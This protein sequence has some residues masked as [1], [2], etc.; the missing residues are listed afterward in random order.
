LNNYP[1]S[2]FAK[3]YTITGNQIIDEISSLIL[4]EAGSGSQKLPFWFC[5]HGDASI[6]SSN[7]FSSSGEI[8]FNFRHIQWASMGG[9]LFFAGFIQKM[10]EHPFSCPLPLRLTPTD[11]G[12]SFARVT[13]ALVAI[14]RAV[15]NFPHIIGN[16]CWQRCPVGQGK[17]GVLCIKEPKVVQTRSLKSSSFTHFEW[18]LIPLSMHHRQSCAFFGVSKVRKTCETMDESFF[19]HIINNQILF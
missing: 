9:T 12:S 16:N 4:G 11:G 17:E 3:T 19:G 2:M 5:L 10:H 6:Q 8:K 7:A 1:S 14:T 15:F 18:K 13:D